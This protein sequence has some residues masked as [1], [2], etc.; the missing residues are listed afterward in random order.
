MNKLLKGSLAL[1]AALC[2]GNMTASAKT[3]TATDIENISKRTIGTESLPQDVYILGK[4]VHLNLITLS[5]MMAVLNS[6]NIDVDTLEDAVLYHLDTDG[7]WTNADTNQAIT[8]INKV[9]FEMVRLVGS[10]KTNGHVS[11]SDDLYASNGDFITTYDYKTGRVYDEFADTTADLMV[12]GVRPLQK[13]PDLGN[14]NYTDTNAYNMTAANANLSK[15]QVK[16]KTIYTLNLTE[17]SPL[18]NYTRT[19][20]GGTKQNGNWIGLLVK[21][22]KPAISSKLS[23]KLIQSSAEKNDSFAVDLTEATKTSCGAEKNEFVLWLKANVL[24]SNFKLEVTQDDDDSREEDTQPIAIEYTSTVEIAKRI[25]SENNL[26]VTVLDNENVKVVYPKINNNYNEIFYATDET[27][28]KDFKFTENDNLMQ[29]VDNSEWKFGD[30]I[31]IKSIVKAEPITSTKWNQNAITNVSEP[32]SH[33]RTETEPYDYVVTITTNHVL[34]DDK[35]VNLV[36]DLSTTTIESL[37][38]GD[39]KTSSPS[40]GK[41]PVTVDF[42]SKNEVTGTFT[43]NNADFIKGAKKLVTDSYTIL[44]VLNDETTPLSF[45]T[46][47]ADKT[48]DLVYGNTLTDA[49]NIN[50]AYK[51]NV[52]AVTVNN[53]EVDEH[54]A[55]KYTVKVQVNSDSLNHFK[56]AGLN[57]VLDKKGAAPNTAGYAWIPVIVDLGFKLQLKEGSVNSNFSL[58]LSNNVAPLDTYSIDK[59][60]ITDAKRLGA[61]SDTAFVVWVLPS[62]GTNDPTFTFTKV[63]TNASVTVTFEVRETSKLTDSNLELKDIDNVTVNS[64]YSEDVK[65]LGNAEFKVNRN[66][67]KFVATIN[68]VEYTYN[69]NWTDK[70][71]T[72]GTLSKIRN[73]VLTAVYK[74]LL[75]KDDSTHSDEKA[76]EF[77][78]KAVS[79]VSLSGNVINVEFDRIVSNSEEYAIVVDLGTKLTEA[80]V[81][82][83]KSS[84]TEALNGNGATVTLITDAAS[85]LST[86]DNEKATGH[87]LAVIHVTPSQ[88]D[89]TLTK[90]EGLKVAITRAVDTN[91]SASLELVIKSHVNDT[92]NDNIELKEE[93]TKTLSVTDDTFTEGDAEQK[94]AEK[95]NNTSIRTEVNENGEIVIY[96]DRVLIPFENEKDSGKEAAYF[97]VLVDLGIDPKQITATKGYMFGAD[98]THL[99]NYKKD[100][101]SVLSLLG[102][103]EEYKDERTEAYLYGGSGNQFILWLDDQCFTDEVVDGVKT[104]RKTYSATFAS[105]GNEENKYS[106]TTITFVLVDATDKLVIDNTTN[107][108]SNVAPTSVEDASLYK[109]NQ[110][111]FSSKYSEKIKGN[112][113][114]RTLTISQLDSEL[115]SYEYNISIDDEEGTPGKWYGIEIDF[116]TSHQD[117]IALAENADENANDAVKL[118]PVGN[119]KTTYILW[120][121]LESESL[122]SGSVKP[123]QFQ[124]LY[125]T[126][127]DALELNIVLDMLEE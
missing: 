74:N 110:D 28:V 58:T 73:F 101:N 15:E 61:D 109:M 47:G 115:S 88:T 7:N 123:I 81:N 80:E 121:N 21:T 48:V 26:E 54:D 34:D 117:G 10:K 18:L 94:K 86:N 98:A 25:V 43:N 16:G 64:E 49:A 2:V 50:A 82:A 70:D 31:D 30:L 106:E 52:G 120:I 66:V 36:M 72:K 5:D 85:R 62:T 92:R 105:L 78:T 56:V 87:T 39:V 1:L 35:T 53:P 4:H 55:N 57:P 46:Y 13:A 22:N 96:Y 107:L 6:G 84:G 126:A 89:E 95:H 99:D 113:L 100:P 38:S 33:K 108:D 9:S 119:S 19:S 51:Y 60:D 65:Y 97:G 79:N 90:G 45:D 63:D 125:D 67:S 40:D 71:N 11:E 29:A 118:E 42:S 69:V 103:T 32:V 8:N 41:I 122:T 127:A 27:E 116:G 83:L 93:D 111:R 59:S 24:D 104:G 23:V 20:K 68:G 112:K 76:I 37:S 44:F 3:M 12:I 17:N 114:T 77:P 14:K 91:Q 75:F 102:T 124:D